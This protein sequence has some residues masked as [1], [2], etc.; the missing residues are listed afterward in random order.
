MSTVL[1]TERLTLRPVTTGD[2]LA[3]HAMLSDERAMRFMPTPPHQKVE[4]TGAWISGELSRSG[5]LYWSVIENASQTI[6]GYV[7]FLGETRFPG[8][9][10]MIHPD[11]WGKGYAP[12]ACR[13]ALDFG[14]SQLNYD[15]VELW[16]DE[17]NAASQRVAHKL[18]FQKKGRIPLK[19]RH[20]PQNHV[21]AIFGIMES[22]WNGQGEAILSTETTFYRSESVLMVHDVEKTTVFYRDHLGFK[23][24]FIFGDPP[25]HAGV[26]RGEWTG[27]S[28]VIQI[29]GVPT[30]REIVP[31]GYLYIFVD[32]SIDQLCASYQENGVEILSK[33][34]DQPWGLRE[35]AIRDL[36]GHTLVFGTHL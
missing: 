36:N 25:E 9:G 23:I 26:S 3:Y 29:T 10:Y 13:A 27:S 33:C 22:E 15:R 31:A 2:M 24:D 34:K 5:A 8:M 18:G 28:V 16:I 11:Y 7:N 17:K 21:M 32:S 19:Y 14:F 35:F 6:V 4:E 20:R 1:T 30:E 12:E